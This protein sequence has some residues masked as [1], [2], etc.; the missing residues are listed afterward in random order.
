MTARV[1]VRRVL[2]HAHESGGFLDIEVFGVL[3]EIYIGGRFDSDGV[4]EE[5]KLVEIHFQ[6]FLF[7]VLLFEL[8]GN[9]PFDGLL[10]CAGKQAVAFGRIQLLGK[11]LSDG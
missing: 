9:H 8:Y 10:H 11:L 7:G 5:V 6:D 4:V 1:K 2:Y 3:A